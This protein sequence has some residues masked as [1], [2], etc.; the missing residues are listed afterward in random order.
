MA[1][2]VKA[3]RRLLIATLVVIGLGVECEAGWGHKAH[4]NVIREAVRVL[5]I[6]DYEMCLY[7]KDDLVKGAIEGEIQFKYRAQGKPPLWMKDL[8]PLEVEL[9]NGIP[10]TAENL[11]EATEFFTKRFEELR[12]DIVLARRQYSEVFFEIG[13]LLH[14]MNNI[15]IPLY[16]K[17]HFPEQHLAAHTQE[18]KLNPE[19]VAKFQELEPWLKQTITQKLAA[20]KLWSGLA[21][22]GDREGF[23]EYAKTANSFNIYSNA[24]II[25]YVLGGSFGPAD[26]E[27]RAEVGKIHERQLD[28]Q[29]GRKPGV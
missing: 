24:A 28:I 1:H 16:E 11:D 17:G 4:S 15:L 9:L 23:I 26:P 10:V 20:R 22:R 29:R 8:T 7:Y 2:G 12:L 21:V 14:S 13:Y 19:L 3:L 5:P 6:F 18:I 27:V 25:H